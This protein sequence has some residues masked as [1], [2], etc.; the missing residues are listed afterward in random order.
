MYPPNKWL[1][2]VI[3]NITLEQYILNPQLKSNAVLNATAREAIRGNYKQKYDAIM[4][5]ERGRLDYILYK[6]SKNNR[7]FA[8]FKIPSETIEKFYYD[9]VLE[10]FADENVKKTN[11]LFS[12]YVKFYSN[13]PAFVYTHVYSFR[14][15]DLFI[16]ELSSK[17]SKKALRTEAKEKNPYNQIGYVKTI[18]FAYLT[19]KNKSLNN[20]EK[21]NAEASTYSKISLLSH[22]MN[23]DNKVGDREAAGAKLQKTKKKQKEKT[24]SEIA[25]KLVKNTLGIKK[26][27]VINSGIK[28]TKY[29]KNTKRK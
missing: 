3:M 14:A 6:D 12:Y 29:V 19:M 1:K 5:R 15:N 13:D 9:V 18:Y 2:E 10:F 24:N 23:A 28:N 16:S 21:F 4:V 17:M 7:Y 22:I 25:T 20:L 8:Y 27:K 11:D 26:T